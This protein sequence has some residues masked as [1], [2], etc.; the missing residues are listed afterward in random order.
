MI[1]WRLRGVT[2]KEVVCSIEKHAGGY[3]L[4]VERGEE[5]M[6]DEAHGSVDEATCKTET[7]KRELTRIGW[8]E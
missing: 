3:R 2:S 4:L 7:F 5:A 8:R 1:L 6:V